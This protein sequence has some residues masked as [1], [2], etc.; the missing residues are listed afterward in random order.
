MDDIKNL[1]AIDIL[2]WNYINHWLSKLNLNT[3]NLI[4]Q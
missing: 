2:D 3:F 4:R 1:C